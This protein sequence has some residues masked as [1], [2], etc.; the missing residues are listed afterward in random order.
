MK[1]RGYHIR[2]CDVISDMNLEFRDASAG[3]LDVVML[4]GGNG[5]GKSF[6]LGSIARAW[7]SSILTGGSVELP[8]VSDLLRIDYELSNEIIGVHIRRGRLDKSSA[9]AKGAEVIVGD[10]PRVKNGIVYYSSNRGIISRSTIRGGFGLCD[11]ICNIFPIIYDLHMRDVRDSIIMVD[12]WDMGLD[13]DARKG[14]YNHLVRHSSG[15]N[16]QV[17]LSSSSIPSS[18]VPFQSIVKLSGRMDPIQS[19]MGFLGK[20]NDFEGI[21]FGI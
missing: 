20:V 16:N 11:S 1:L 17:I 7:S 10:K 13:E 4:F 8:Y 18:W 14:F 19:S 15:R 9:L 21:S 12:D 2:G 6:I 3:I 5:S